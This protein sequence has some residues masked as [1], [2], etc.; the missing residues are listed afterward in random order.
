M[1]IILQ[2]AMKAFVVHKNSVLI[3]RESSSYD[4]PNQGKWDV[5]GGRVKPGEIFYEGLRRE[6]QEESGLIVILGKP[7]S[8]QE[9]R[10]TIKGIEHQII[11]TFIEC[12]SNSSKTRLSKDH[13][14]YEWINPHDYRKYD[15][16]G[17]LPRAFE[18]YL[19]KNEN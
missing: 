19:A 7:F 18:D 6:I 16:V 9:W 12:F 1:G 4:S 13:D 14:G 17:A 10:P 2:L 15:L 11:G 8:V 3:L 5:P